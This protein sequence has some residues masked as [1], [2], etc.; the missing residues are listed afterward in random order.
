MSIRK[1]TIFT[2]QDVEL[3]DYY[4][5]S[6][7]TAVTYSSGKI[8]FNTYNLADDIIVKKAGG[9]VD[10]KLVFYE[11]LDKKG[12]FLSVGDVYIFCMLT[13][14]NG[15]LFIDNPYAY[16]KLDAGDIKALNESKKVK[17]YEE[18][19]KNEKIYERER[20]KSK[21]EKE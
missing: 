12:A 6:S 7:V 18:A 1:D 14:E 9:Y 4:E 17:K 21:Y 20:F 8:G 10:N 5:V 11:T 3:Y 15:D 16:E 2:V 19:Y 13:Q